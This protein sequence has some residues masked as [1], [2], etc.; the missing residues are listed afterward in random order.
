MLRVKLLQIEDIVDRFKLLFVR[1]GLRIK[2]MNMLN[3]SALIYTQHWYDTV[4]SSQSEHRFHT[5][6]KELKKF[7]RMLEKKLFHKSG[8]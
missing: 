4:N 7:E 3:V 8:Y 1:R 2:K 5:H 6:T